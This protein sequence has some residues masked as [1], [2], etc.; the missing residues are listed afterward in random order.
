M[1]NI[2][3]GRVVSVRFHHKEKGIDQQGSSSVFYRTGNS[4]ILI[5]SSLVEQFVKRG[6]F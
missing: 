4:A 2:R 6:G 5:S 3:D 1:M